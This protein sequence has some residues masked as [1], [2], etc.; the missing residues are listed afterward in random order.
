VRVATPVL[1]LNGPNLG[2]L[3]IREPEEWAAP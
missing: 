3:G 1:A 2:R